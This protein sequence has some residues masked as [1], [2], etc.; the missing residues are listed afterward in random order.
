MNRR[1]S[2][3][4][5][6]EAC[7]VCGERLRRTRENY[8]LPL[9]GNWGVTVEGVE[10]IHCPSCGERGISI[11]RLG[12]LMRGIAAALV[13]KHARLAAP[14]ITFLRKH[15]DFT[16]ARLARTLGVTG[17]SVSRWETGKEPIGPSADR[18]L[19][20]LV[21]IHDREADTFDPSAFE[22]IEDGAAPVRLTLRRDAKGNWRTA[23]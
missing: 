15:M 12:P 11:E 9:V 8:R 4:S 17:P 2:A 1:K 6:V 18:L 16:G 5:A 3:K 22:A 10:I 7:T 23:A 14:E 13:R 20:T 19:R 21:V